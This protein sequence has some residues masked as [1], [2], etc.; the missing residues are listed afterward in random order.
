MGENIM[1]GQVVVV[2]FQVKIVIYFTLKSRGGK[3]PPW[4]P[5]NKAL[6]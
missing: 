6:L 2:V 5:I 4:P 1:G 3:C